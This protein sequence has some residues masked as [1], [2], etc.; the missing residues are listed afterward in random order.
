MNFTQIALTT[1]VPNKKQASQQEN[2]SLTLIH[3]TELGELTGPNVT[4]LGV[5]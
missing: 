2:V 3:N 4:C 1:D 5:S